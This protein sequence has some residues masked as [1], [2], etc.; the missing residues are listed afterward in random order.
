M[1]P[2]KCGIV[3]AVLLG[4][5]ALS[6][7]AGSTARVE[8][9]ATV[10]VTVK[11]LIAS[12]HRMEVDPGT[13]VVWDDPHF[14]RVWFPA[15]SGAPALERR[16]GVFQARFD[17]AGTYRGAFTLV[18]SHGTRDVQSMTVVVRERR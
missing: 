5:L 7:L 6:G 9:I 18:G 4:A 13:R 15:G 8:P 3:L 14:E 16:A 12:G 2:F 1:R 11:D 17:R 10:T